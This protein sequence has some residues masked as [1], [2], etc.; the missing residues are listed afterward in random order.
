MLDLP[1]LDVPQ[2]VQHIVF[3]QFAVNEF[4]NPQIIGAFVKSPE[5]QAFIPPVAS[6]SD[7]GHVNFK[8]HINGIS[9][10]GRMYSINYEL[11]GVI[12]STVGTFGLLAPQSR[13]V[14]DERVMEIC[15]RSFKLNPEW[16]KRASAASHNRAKQYHRVIQDMNRIDNEISSNHAKT[17]SDM[18]EEFYKVITEQIETFDP[19][20]KKT[21]YL[22]MYNNAYTDGQGNYFLRDYDDGTLPFDNA[23]EWRKLNIINRNETK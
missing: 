7:Y 1:L 19:V 6:R 15:I 22:P 5:L 17:N 11:Q 20:T 18:Q 4:Q 14:Q 23:S 12:W 21:K 16:V 8:C 13:W 2:Y 3:N 10:Y 9:M